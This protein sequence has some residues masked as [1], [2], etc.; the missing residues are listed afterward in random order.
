MTTFYA[1]PRGILLSATLIIMLS[2]VFSQASAQ[3][4]TPVFRHL[5]IEN[6]LSNYLVT[7]V[8][9][10]DIG[11][12][13]FST[14][15]GLNRYDGR[16]IVHYFH[17]ASDSLG[18]SGNKLRAMVRDEDGHIWLTTNHGV[19][20]YNPFTEVFTHFDFEENIN[21]IASDGDKGIWAGTSAGLFLLKKDSKNFVLV[22]F[23]R[24]PWSQTISNI[25]IRKLHRAKDNTLWV[26]T[27]VGLY[28]IDNHDGLGRWILPCLE[29]S[30]TKENEFGV[31]DIAVSY[32]GKNLWIASKEGL[33]NLNEQKECLIPYRVNGDVPFQN[34]S[35][36]VLS[37]DENEKLWLGNTDALGIYTL[38]IANGVV[39]H[40]SNLLNKN[41]AGS[42]LTDIFID[43]SG[44][45][46]IASTGNGVH[47]YDPKTSHFQW[48]GE[49]DQKNEKNVDFIRANSVYIDSKGVKWITT[50]SGIKWG[51]SLGAKTYPALQ[52]NLS[53][54]KNGFYR[55]YELPN[56]IFWAGTVEGGIMRFNSST[57]NVRFY[58]ETSTL[59]GGGEQSNIVTAFCRDHNDNVWLGFWGGGMAYIDEKNLDYPLIL[60]C[61]T[62][63]STSLGACYIKVI[64]EDKKGTLWIGDA[65]GGGLINYKPETGDFKRYLPDPNNENSLS[66]EYVRTI[67]ED[68]NGKLYLGT[69]GGG[70]SIFNPSTDTFQNF[71]T[72][73]G[74][75]NDFINALAKDHNDRL[76]I[77]TA[78]ALSKFDPAKGIFENFDVENGLPKTQL[79]GFT[80][81]DPTTQKMI[82]GTDKGYVVFHP[83]SIEVDQMSPKTHIVKMERYS[84]GSEN[85]EPILEKGIAY[86]K[87]INLSYDDYIV[88]F[89]LAAITFRK[90]EKT[91]IAYKLEGFHN[92]WI[93]LGNK[94]Q[95]SFTS[96]PANNYRLMVKSA[97]ADGVWNEM[98]T[99]LKINVNPPWWK[100][101]WAYSFFILFIS[102]ILW[103]FIRREFRRIRLQNQLEKEQLERERLKEIDE[104]KSRFL[105]NISHE[106][107]TPLTVILSPL[108]DL[109]NSI[110]NSKN[111]Q[112]LK[113]I[114]ANASRLLGL[115]N[116]LMDLS[117]IQDKK[118]RLN[119]V[120]Q[121]LEIFIE[122]LCESFQPIAT[123]KE[124]DFELN[125]SL[126]ERLIS[127]DRDAIEKIVSNLL[128]N[129]YKFTPNKGTIK[130]ESSIVH[131]DEVQFVK[132][133]VK[134]SG[135]G[136]SK[137]Q[138]QQIFE[139]FYQV[140]QNNDKFLGTGIGLSLVKELVDLHQGKI[141]VESQLG[142]GSTFTVLLPTN[143]TP[144]LY[145]GEGQ[146]H[147]AST[148]LKQS[149]QQ[150]AVKGQ[151]KGTPMNHQQDAPIVLIIDDNQDI[152]HLISETLGDAYL[153]IQAVD[154]NDGLRQALETVPDLIISDIMMPGMDG[155]ELCDHLKRNTITSHIP[156]IL[157]T[158]KASH[159]SKL[160]GLKLGA[161][162]YLT[163]PFDTDELRIRVDNLISSRRVLKEKYAASNSWD[164][165]WQE[166]PVKEQSF[167]D[168]LNNFL[169]KHIKNPDLSVVD[170]AQEMTIGERQLRRKMKALTNASPRQY[171]RSYRLKLACQYLLSK[172]TD[173][174]AIAF[175]VGFG[176]AAYFS[177]CFKEAFGKTPGEYKEAHLNRR[178]D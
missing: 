17:N 26:G 162:V 45:V 1:M 42:N 139:R 102:F 155:Y 72:A 130:L 12:L 49:R 174:S 113:M 154:G 62:Q 55:V 70:L 136:I 142:S 164:T 109:M 86:R 117:K 119:L 58:F 124:I 118:V 50:D 100:T 82:L 56:G 114:K 14:D 173:I 61:D 165:V 77:S 9:Q 106:F 16:E 160:D 64:R 126:S 15:H 19:D 144:S 51:D 150:N 7:E 108:D 59:L 93:Q 80:G 157:L 115:V 89:E 74:L 37:L 91:Q 94:R 121:P 141:S 28:K 44:L 5:D 175:D 152:R 48:F 36:R 11:F 101:W 85:G 4:P 53:Q 52:S 176:S 143:L 169:D 163:K 171:L 43:D 88:T 90:A 31:H 2:H 127:F 13:W 68:D 3:E 18:I 65:Y 41:I 166:L 81:P 87:E 67:V 71:T 146:N 73:D 161:D 78:T 33:F 25:S 120:E 32:S 69:S 111:I 132:I 172:E 34:Q 10:D 27:N 84:R 83:D 105:T 95:I 6:G 135:V 40:L 97:N 30:T 22:D 23:A 75:P 39:T 137:N 98:P 140:D 66:H 104:V 149:M 116:Q 125:S 54:I 158:A 168:Q 170:I 103:F 21:S 138:V 129:A 122:N 178:T 92:D 8:V 29:N 79:H 35:I 177:K 46:W 123:K 131:L 153:R 24:H 112:T 60:P 38:D 128:S 110:N 159:H 148:G 63:D 134:D 57:G 151:K 47:I 76:W 133:T 145:Q 20:K 96:L 107:R 167:I 99:E 147:L 156:V